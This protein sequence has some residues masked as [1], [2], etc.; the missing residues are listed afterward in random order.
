MRSFSKVFPTFSLSAFFGGEY[1]FCFGAERCYSTFYFYS[2]TYM[3][4][5]W[6]LTSS[7]NLMTL[8]LIFPFCEG[9]LLFSKGTE[10]FVYIL[11]GTKFCKIC[12]RQFSYPSLWIHSA[13]FRNSLQLSKKSLK[14]PMKASLK[15]ATYLLP[16]CFLQKKV[17]CFA[18]MFILTL[19]NLIKFQYFDYIYAC[20]AVFFLK[21]V[22]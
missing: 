4:V 15:H 22:K 11:S 3:F 1:F 8:V 17:V 18:T 12:L 9:T 13:Y 6:H 10:G 21:T 7:Q 5:C 16:S 2:Y 20:C 14:F 19:R